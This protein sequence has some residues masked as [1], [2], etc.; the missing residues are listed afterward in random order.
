MTVA[1]KIMNTVSPLLNSSLTSPI[2][3]SLS[4]KFANG[5]AGKAD[6]FGTPAGPRANSIWLTIEKPIL[7]KNKIPITS[8]TTK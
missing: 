1:G 2:W 3:N 5:A 7:D 4:R 8:H 6:F